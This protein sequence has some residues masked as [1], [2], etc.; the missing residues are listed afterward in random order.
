M[1]A[2]PPPRAATWLLNRLAP[3]E[4]NGA[5]AGDLVEEYQRR[6]SRAW[7]WKQ[8]LI[9]I[10]VEAGR[11]IRL[12]KLLVVRALVIGFGALSL[13]SWLLTRLALNVLAPAVPPSWFAYH[14]V[15]PRGVELAA[16]LLMCVSTFGSSWIVARLHRAHLA[17]TLLVYFASFVAYGVA[18]VASVPQRI[19][20]HSYAYNLST[21]VAVTALYSACVV[22]GG[23]SASERPSR[24][25]G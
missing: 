25:T 14:P 17:A 9:A 24:Q 18:L 15:F 22:A 12:H 1:S 13:F 10:A 6:R 19:P 16:A 3:G 8:V 23:V 4:R 11:D 21:W 7:Y 5:L 2:A 20:Y